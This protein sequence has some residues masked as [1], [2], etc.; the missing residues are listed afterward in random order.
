MEFKMLD[1]AIQNF[2]DERK[3]SRIKEKSKNCKTDEDIQKVEN[4][5]I[6]EF[7]LENWLPKAAKRAGSLSISTHPC[8]FTHPSSRNH[9]DK[10]KT[11]GVIANSPA[12]AD[13]FLRTGNSD[14]DLDV[15]GNAAALDVHKFL[16]L[17]VSDGQTVLTHL[18]QNSDY[19]QNQFKLTATVPSE[20]IQASLFDE[21]H[22]EPFSEIHQGLLAMKQVDVKT[23]IT[24]ER[25]KQ[26][27]FP[28]ADDY[29]LLSILT[30]SGLMFK[31]RQRIRVGLNKRHQSF[32]GI[33]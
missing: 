28:V 33:F 30:P 31:L 7:S 12:K 32:I 4:A 14:A 19:I 29:H 5:A 10:Q 23:Y 26:V 22:I 11:T 13:G 17:K 2:L 1:T 25:V 6:E 8:T 21:S 15:V 20:E 9:P 3:D 18:E 27:Y 16:S 24:S